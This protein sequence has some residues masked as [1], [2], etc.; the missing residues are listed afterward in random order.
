MNGVFMNGWRFS[1]LI[2]FEKQAFEQVQGNIK[3]KKS[4][5]SENVNTGNEHIKKNE[6]R[7][8]EIINIG[9]PVLTLAPS[10]TV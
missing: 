4:S 1:R 2:L 5:H 8:K 6:K 10:K 7:H 9:N 3:N